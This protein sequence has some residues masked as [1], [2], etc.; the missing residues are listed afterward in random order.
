VSV[1]ELPDLL[2]GILVAKLEEFFH[3]RLNTPRCRVIGRDTFVE[4]ALAPKQCK[5]DDDWQWNAQQPKQRSSTEA[6][7]NLHVRPF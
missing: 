3:P 5:Q 7:V 2:Q 6:H 1:D 4:C